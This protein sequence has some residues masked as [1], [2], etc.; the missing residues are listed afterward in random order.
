MQPPCFFS[1]GLGDGITNTHVCLQWGDGIWE[2]FCPCIMGQ[3]FHHWND[4]YFFLNL[5][6]LVSS[7]PPLP[8]KGIQRFRAQ[9]DGIINN[10]CSTCSSEHIFTTFMTPVSNWITLSTLKQQNRA[11]GLLSSPIGFLIQWCNVIAKRD[12]SP[13]GFR[14]PFQAQAAYQ[15]RPKLQECSFGSSSSSL[16]FCLATFVSYCIMLI[17]SMDSRVDY[18]ITGLEFILCDGR[19]WFLNLHWASLCFLLGLLR[20]YSRTCSVVW[21]M[22]PQADCVY[23]LKHVLM[24]YFF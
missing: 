14:L 17:T 18:G 8:L 19:N 16:W 5:T 21:L 22:I 12:V 6:N 7:L 10:I 13:T 23:V 15:T 9:N 4:P 2:H 1:M 11:N 24:V 3:D 20:Y